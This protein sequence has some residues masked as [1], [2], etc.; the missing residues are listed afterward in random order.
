MSFS[1]PSNPD[2]EYLI[3]PGHCA[4]VADD[5]LGTS[6]L[7]RNPDRDA[8]NLPGHCAASQDDALHPVGAALPP[9]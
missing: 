8:L 1:L 4:A 2:R 9:I 6:P 3:L 7:S 5:A